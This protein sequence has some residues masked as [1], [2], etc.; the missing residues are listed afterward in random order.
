MRRSKYH[1]VGYFQVDHRESPGLRWE[2]IPEK[3]RNAGMR[4][5]GKGENFEAD[6]YNCTHCQRMIV[7]AA[8]HQDMQ[9]RGYCPKCDHFI[10]NRCEK[11]RVATGFCWSVFRLLDTAYEVAQKYVGDPEHPNAKVDVLQLREPPPV[12]IALTDAWRTA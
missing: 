9:K 12:R 3:A 11:L 1:G 5:V 4:P 8:K 6:A 10:C 7:L 2:D